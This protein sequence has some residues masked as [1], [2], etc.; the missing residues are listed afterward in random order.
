MS[1]SVKTKRYLWVRD[2]GCCFYCGRALPWDDNERTMDHVI[3]KSKG[4]P[5]RTWNLVLACSPCNRKKGDTD[6]TP[7]QLDLVLRRK[8]LTE[9]MISIG[10][11]IDHC[12]KQARPSEAERLVKLQREISEMILLGSLPTDFQLVLSNRE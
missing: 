12:K 6:P 2:R 3:P 9:H 4:G 1:K 10:Q 7:A 11:A 8:L 5:H